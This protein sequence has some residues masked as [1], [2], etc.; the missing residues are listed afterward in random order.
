MG[1][2]EKD[3]IQRLIQQ[4]AQVIAAALKLNQAGKHEEAL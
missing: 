2:F 3:F 1:L 4:F